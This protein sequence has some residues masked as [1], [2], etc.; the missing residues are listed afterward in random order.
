M[1]K[2]GKRAWAKA[3][4]E[5]MNTGMGWWGGGRGRQQRCLRLWGTGGSGKSSQER[6]AQTSRSSKIHLSIRRPSVLMHTLTTLPSVAPARCL[7]SWKDQV[8]AL[9]QL[10]ANKVTLK[11]RLRY[12]WAVIWLHTP[13]LWPPA[14][15][16]HP[17]S[18]R[19]SVVDLYLP[20]MGNEHQGI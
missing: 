4:T 18:P 20:L 15:P 13:D 3:R 2:Y 12:W 11:D 14:V 17:I 19:L 10:T 8:H 5:G 9:D 1:A 7:V 16:G 6:M